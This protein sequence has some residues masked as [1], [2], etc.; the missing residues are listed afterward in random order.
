MEARLKLPFVS[1]MMMMV[2]KTTS[3][4]A[5]QNFCS[6][7]T[8]LRTRT[9]C[10]SCSISMLIPCPSGFRQTAGSVTQDCKYF[11]KTAS[12][13]LQI[14]GCSFGCHREE[15]LKSCCPGFW[16]P[17]CQECPERADRPCSGRGTCS[18]GLGGNGTCSCQE[19]FAGTACE[20]CT[21]G[22]YGPTC[23]SVCSCVHGLCDS[24]MTGSGLCTC[25]SGYSGP[26]CDRELPA[27]AALNCQQNSRC[28]EEAL[29][30]QLVCQ[31]MPGYQKS[32][33]QCV[34]INPCVR[35]LCHAQAACIHT[36]PNQHMCV[37]NEGYTGDGR[38][39]IAIDPCQ[40]KQG[41]CSAESTRCVF[42]RPGKSH[43][44]CLPGYEN[45]H[46]GSCS[47]TDLCRPGSCHEHANCTTV[48]PGRIDC[49]CHQGY[50]GNG[51]VCYGN[52]IQRL[53]DLNTEPT[54]EWRGQLSNAIQLFSVLSWPLQSLGPFT[55]FVPINK[56]FRGTSLRTL[57]ANPAKAKYLCKMHLVAGVMPFSS[58]KKTNIFYTITG[59]SAETD[60]SEGDTQTK[61]RLHGSRK[62][63]VILRSDVVAS[64]GMI[65]IINKLMDSVAPTVESDTQENLM[66]IISDYGKFITLKSF[67]EKVDLDIVLDSPGPVTVFAP[68]FMAFNMMNEGYLEHLK[69]AE[70]RHK[71]L[72]FMRNHLVRSTEL[73][74]F[75]AVSSPRIV[76]MANQVLN[77]NVTENGR[78][79]V[80]DAA[81]IEAA[82]EAKNG[83]MY[84]LDGVL[85]PPSIEPVLPHR[86]DITE[87]KVIKGTCVSCSKAKQ[88]QCS[89]GV[90]ANSSIYGC[91]YTHPVIQVPVVGCSP[92]C[93]ANIT[94]PVCCKGFY[95]PDCISCPGGY[96]TPCSGHGQ[97]SDGITGTG[98]C[99]CDQNFRG[100]RC[101]YCSASNKYGPN[102][103][104]TCPCVHGQCDNRADSDGRCKTDTC[105]SGFTGPLCD[106]R[107][108]AC[109]VNAQFCHAH[110]DCDFSQGNP[111][112][113]CK[114]GYQ[115]DGITCVE[116]DPCAPPRR[117]GCSVNAKCIKTGPGTHSCQ[118]L[119]GWKE[120]GDD[121]Q[122][123]NNCERPDNGGCHPN[124]TCI[125]VG[126]GQSDCSCKAG[127]KGSGWDCEAVNQCVTANGGCH[128]LASC[129]LLSSQWTCVCDE[130]Y[131]G[132]GQTCYGT[133]RQ[134]LTAMQGVSEFSTWTTDSG[135][136]WSLADQNL[137]LLVPSSDAVAKMSPEDKTFWTTKGNLPSLIRNHMIQG[138]YPLSRLSS[139]P[140]LTS[141]L[142][143]TLPVSTTNDVTA[144]G[145][146]TITTSNVAATNGLIHIID[147]V[148]VPDRKLSEGLLATLALKTDFS[149]FRSYLINYNLTDEIEQADEFTVFAPTDAA[150]ADYLKKMSLTAMD[151]NTTRYHVVPTERLLKTD[152]QPGGYKETLLGISYQLGF[153]PRDG[154]LFVN[155]AQLNSSNLL[156]GHGVIHGLSTVLE[157]NKNRCDEVKYQKFQGPCVD[158]LFPR[159]DICPN[160]TVEDKSVKKRKCMMS[161]VFEE[162]RLL[163]IGCK[164]TCLQSNIDWKCCGGFFG[165]HCEPC[166]GPKGHPCSGNGQCDD[167]T[168]GTGL[169]RCSKGFVGTACESCESGKYSVHC[170]Q[171]CR[172]KNG[173]CNEGVKGDG[174][175]VCD[176][177]WRGIL[178]DEKTESEELCG[179]VK[180]HTSANCLQGSSASFCSCAAGF[181]GNGTFCKARDP[182]SVSN[183]GC[184]PVAVCKRTS[185]GLRECVCGSGYRGDGLVCVEINPCLEG[186]DG[187]HA[188][189][190]C[191]HVGPNKTSCACRDGFHGN[192]QDCKMIDLCKKRHGGCHEYAKCN[193]TAPG[194]RTCTCTS[195]YIGDG[196]S[197]RGTVGKEILK[198]KLRDFYMALIVT[199]ISLKGRG[200][201]TVFV[202]TADAF[203][204]EK[205]GAGRFKK[206]TSE[207]HF[208][209]FSAILRSHIVM[210]HTLQ[211]ADLSQ[212]R[213]MTSLSGLVLTTRSNQGSIFIN[214][215]NVTYSHGLSTNGVFHE[216]NRILFPPKKDRIEDSDRP[217]NLSDIADRH[218][219]KTFYRLL[220]DSG[221]MDL[222][223]DVMYRPVTVFLPSDNVM[224]SLPQ[225]QKDFLFHKDNKAQLQEYLKFHI[226]HSQKVYAEGLIHLDSPRTLQGSPLSFSCGG[227][228]AIGEVF[229]NDGKCRIVQ[230]HLAFNGGIAYGIEC[231]L[232]PPS[233]GGHCI[234]PKTLDL[235][236]SCEVCGSSAARCP[237]G[238]KLKDVEKC[239]L[240]S[241]YINKNSGCRS[242]CTVSFFKPKCCV[243]YY[244]R[245]CQACPGGSSS[246]CNNHGKCDDGHLGNGTCTC[247]AGFGGVACEL[248][249]EGF[250]GGSCK[251][252]NCSEHGSCDQ[253]RTG[254]GACF[255]EAGWTGDR[256]E[257]QQT[258]V[259]QCSPSCSPKGI[260]REN[261]TCECLRFYV[262]DGYACKAMDICSVW[263]GG[264]AKGAKCSQV[265]EQVTC[266]CPKFHQGDGYTCLP[267]D[268]C[269]SG[270]N[271]GCHEHATCTM[272]APGK[273]KCT[274]KDNYIGDGVT[275]EVKQ[276]PI[277]RCLQDNG[278]CH[279]DAKCTDL[280]YED[281]KFGVF[282]YR[283]VKGQYK[284]TYS[285]A[286][287]ACI[288]EGGSLATYTQLSY[289]QQGGL[290]MCAAGWLDAAR[291]GYPTTY[292]NPQCGFGHIGI[293]D[294]GT[295]KNLSETWDTFCFRIKEVKCECNPDYVGDG[296]SCVGN[297]LQI[298]K[299]TPNFSNFLTQILN[300]SRVSDSGKQF[301]KRLSNLTIQSTLFVPDNGG[302]P[303]NQVSLCF[304][305]SCPHKEKHLS[306]SHLSCV[307]IMQTLSMRDLEL[308]LSEGQALPLDQLKN[309]THIRTR[310]GA[311]TVLGIADLMNPS[312]LSSRYINNRF[313]TTSDIQAANG[314]IHVLQGPL[315]APPPRQAMQ[316]AHKAGVGVGVVVLIILLVAVVFVGYHFYTHKTSPFM[317]HYFKEEDEAEE[318]APPTPEEIPRTICNPVYEAAPEP[319]ESGSSEAAVEDTHE[320][321]DGGSY[322]LLPADL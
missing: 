41:G 128:Y 197:C 87:T 90:F 226:L 88:S 267:I 246:P 216:I 294:Y 292:S 225:E 293:V 318:E 224:A 142:K 119:S 9:A 220:E 10:H 150:I 39:C 201:F 3:A 111:R 316:V 5:Q 266:T 64:N 126:P 79:L 125:Y 252:C 167:G 58:L 278:Q 190:E 219:Y 124:A 69:S 273:K 311:L 127:Y 55:L 51:K 312:A 34:S 27:C 275:C 46:Q 287:Q 22:R 254:T 239:D 48:E 213:N 121:C 189:A 263:N 116:A 31:C 42:D 40:T 281:A 164:A 157:I 191:I 182:C 108:S 15:V 288:A 200:P 143:T 144:V 215:A 161:R 209:E 139:L 179:S 71:L 212:P 301:V 72:E 183:G 240:P 38:V 23:S 145:G 171:D 313:I 170:D 36:G 7:S 238:S 60:T 152:L 208:E 297:L 131:V 192:G 70:G 235:Q 303:D 94:T 256:C 291:V 202:P 241:V 29:T 289:A 196:F 158:C 62:K 264:C 61:I 73:E 66:R 168:A 77:I 228:D 33:D 50:L 248:C 306:F 173:R 261:N 132:D 146:A 286:Q 217:V 89:S 299:S 92:L 114:P 210:C 282:H 222:V 214:E 242:I 317:F 134:E 78:I 250:Y 205:Q 103:D 123:V 14:S 234:E 1:V 159:S 321:V 279:Q 35:P 195:S 247:D 133:I 271:G 13:K 129:L 207:K 290:N 6:N 54:G 194:V 233:L 177:G 147:K 83:R 285:E 258:E 74:V 140:S 283:S 100:F 237:K 4:A 47:L 184:S 249:S 113:I 153:Y 304:T 186:N 244:G 76:T 236:M 175:C 93:N 296:L 315:K 165:T 176:V 163:T 272:T 84:V 106:R 206:L 67:L 155:D 75:N 141:L 320:V 268:P 81:V 109:G 45:L 310:V 276:K 154:K 187:C 110:A 151:V 181:E 98:T 68:T 136:S 63:G 8:V 120:D 56:G 118:C 322:D 255:C 180:C 130:G 162:G 24:G 148:L 319:A 174:S 21:S 295:R 305:L 105:Q 302:L 274:C 18:E 178:C 82:V 20:L 102:C 221:V 156:S 298:L 169:C 309:G 199:Q 253:G 19:G 122:P 96:Q 218:G 203:N 251:A 185:P 229:V 28:M 314:V 262:G 65:H 37:C 12:L 44:E 80:N 11:I 2:M 270:D 59:K 269:A 104:R 86:C 52:I 307:S 85:I 107:T 43:C 204:E 30:G 300:S 99:V 95:G 198:R 230:R 117:G 259:L 257:K 223:G 137:T 231:L 112:C 227:S 57:A 245:D 16:G 32:G 160:K 260:C 243:G 25:F 138:V 26:S 149:L 101:Q 232:T 188:D 135:L 277:S 265:G 280:H 211:S 17:D 53:N 308:H 166:P 49:T 91:L 193:M 115:G 172:C 284:L 97:C